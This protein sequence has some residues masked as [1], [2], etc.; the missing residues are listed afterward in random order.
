MISVIEGLVC[1]TGVLAKMSFWRRTCIL[2]DGLWTH[3]FQFC[4]TS[5]GGRIFAADEVLM[6]RKAIRDGIPHPMVACSPKRI[7]SRCHSRYA[8]KSKIVS[9]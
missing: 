6:C 9:D 5:R 3:R 1:L 4:K 8:E 2:Q 7:L